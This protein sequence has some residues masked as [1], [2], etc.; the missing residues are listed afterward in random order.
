MTQELFFSYLKKLVAVLEEKQ[1]LPAVLLVDNHKAHL[2]LEIVE[3]CRKH[4][5]VLVG[6]PANT[7]SKTQPLD[8]T[9]YRCVGWLLACSLFSCLTRYFGRAVKRAYDR[10]RAQ[11][12]KGVRNSNVLSVA[13]RA[14]L[15][16]LSKE[17][18]VSG[19]ESCGIWPLD[20]ERLLKSAGLQIESL[21]KEVE[22]ETK[23]VIAGDKQAMPP[24]D[25]A[26]AAG[27]HWLSIG[28][29]HSCLA[30]L[31]AQASL[32]LR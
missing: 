13:S 32:P 9:C 19:F 1:L 22:Q 24:A 17:A 10:I 21:V 20:P 18:I 8:K 31:G 6:F 15:E 29:A 7:T 30:Q 11:L 26:T 23:A 28:S 12:P 4:K 2:S 27:S 14:L 3:F 25:L 5:L 16:G